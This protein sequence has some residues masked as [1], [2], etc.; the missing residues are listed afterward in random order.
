MFQGGKG[1]KEEIA[2]AGEE[3]REEELLRGK[4]GRKRGK[5]KRITEGRGLEGERERK[6]ER[7]RGREGEGVERK[8]EAG[9][10]VRCLECTGGVEESVYCSSNNTQP[11]H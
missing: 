11:N 6:R 2:K 10:R 4:R 3:R 5:K 9:G 1:E 7:E 8:R